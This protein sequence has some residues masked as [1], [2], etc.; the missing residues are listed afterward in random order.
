MKFNLNDLWEDFGDV[1]MNPDTEEIEVSWNGFPAGT[2][3]EAI[4]RWFEITFDISVAELLYGKVTS[5]CDPKMD[6]VQK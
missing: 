2:H 3:R 1:P 5:S 6:R 4:W